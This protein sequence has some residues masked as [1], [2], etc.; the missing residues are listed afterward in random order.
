MYACMLLKHADELPVE[1]QEEL[2]DEVV[3]CT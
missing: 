3:E 2:R 1:Y